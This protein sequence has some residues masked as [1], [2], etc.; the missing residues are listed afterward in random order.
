MLW[1]IEE[2][3][4]LIIKEPVKMQLGYHARM[5]WAHV[6]FTIVPARK[7]SLKVTKCRFLSIQESPFYKH[8]QDEFPSVTIEQDFVETTTDRWARS[9]QYIIFKDDVD[10]VHFKL[11]YCC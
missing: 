4:A 9:E 8:L 6:A 1:E 2:F 7:F 3:D 10:T 11:K 5:A